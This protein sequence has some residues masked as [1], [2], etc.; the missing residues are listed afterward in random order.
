[1]SA[2]KVNEHIKREIKAQKHE[3]HELDRQINERIKELSKL[4]SQ[5][6]GIT[7]ISKLPPEVLT[8]IFS[9]C[10]QMEPF[11]PPYPY[12]P[13]T[14][15]WIKI[16]HV[17]RHW[18]EI[19]LN[20][21]S[22]WH[23][24]EF[25]SPRWTAEM[26]K[27]SKN[28]PLVVKADLTYRAPSFGMTVKQALD[29]V[30]RIKDLDL[31]APQQTLAMLSDTLA[32]PAP[33][34][35]SLRLSSQ[36]VS[37]YMDTVY[38]IPDSLFKATAP[39]LRCLELV[40]CEIDWNSVFLTNLTHL[41]IEK[42]H[43]SDPGRPTM[44][45]FLKVLSSTPDLQSLRLKH[46]APYD[47]YDFT[48][49]I[50]HVDLPL[51]SKALVNDRPEYTAGVLSRLNM[52]HDVKLKL[53][54]KATSGKENTLEQVL[55]VVGKYRLREVE[56]R[57]H[58]ESLRIM[59]EYGSLQVIGGS[60]QETCIPTLAAL[61]PHMTAAVPQVDLILTWPG[62]PANERTRSIL[63]LVSASL[64]LHEV[65]SLHVYSS[66]PMPVESWSA[67]FAKLTKLRSLKIN[68]YRCSTLIECFARST[69]VSRPQ[70]ETAT[71]IFPELRTISMNDADFSER[72]PENME[73]DVFSAFRDWLE[74]RMLREV[75]VDNITL[76]NCT[77]I[78]EAKVAEL[79][80]RIAG[81]VLWDG[82][83]RQLSDD[84]GSLDDWHYTGGTYGFGVSDDDVDFDVND[85]EAIFG[86]PF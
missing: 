50:D 19:A 56:E 52:P 27:R 35:E 80:Q 9:I 34:L 68:G 73:V 16:T 37:A 64:D 53:D 33:F 18:R 15:P 29:H 10:S 13:T 84:E 66:E 5:R 55:A 65:Q 20:C 49:D 51:L 8:Q 44:A 45:Q 46:A 67:T 3:L 2:H 69:P 25:I 61:Y 57:T 85:V 82:V 26:L 41:H 23:V 28:A 86:F 12:G 14:P 54:C 24:I 81:M 7:P 75:P 79:Q 47:P 4:R 60:M 1:M 36:R 71:I 48:G 40:N 30:H 63:S 77:H 62:G 74:F 17:C 58:L 42:S 76:A 78:S 21:S 43:A 31:T 72:L 32:R 70:R 11:G 22:L 59:I 6:N 39:R 38:R 83:D